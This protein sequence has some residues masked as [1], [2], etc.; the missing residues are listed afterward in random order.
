MRG[1]SDAR[2]ACRLPAGR[3]DRDCADSSAARRRPPMRQTLPGT[4]AARGMCLGRARLVQPSRYTVDNRPLDEDEI[5]GELERLHLALDTARQELHE[6]RS[7]LHGAL[8][9]EVNEFIDAHSLL[10][11]DPE[12]LRGL[13]DLVRIGHYRA[14]AA[15][16]KQR[17]R[18]RRGVRGD[19]RPLPAQ[20]PRRRR[21]GDQPGD[22]RAA[23]AD[24][25]GGTQARRARGRDPGR[26]HHRPGRHGPAGRP[27]PARRG[28]P[29]PAAPIR[30]A[31]SWRAA[32]TCRCWSARAMRCP[33]STTTT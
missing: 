32:S 9:R 22:L 7:K 3:V 25:P 6:L 21:P 10:L 31:R 11:D 24:Q 17:D 4:V 33:A 20:P 28:R 19:G 2:A 30:T 14:G 18:C 27:R 26:R 23:A 29:A 8:A 13:D 16:K 1:R 15:L 5:D 12:M